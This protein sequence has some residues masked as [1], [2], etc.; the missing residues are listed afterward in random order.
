MSFALIVLI[1]LIGFL[2]FFM[3]KLKLEPANIRTNG[4]G[5]VTRVISG[6][7]GSVLLI[8][9]VWL[10]IKDYNRMYTSVEKEFKISAPT[11]KVKKLKNNENLENFRVLFQIIAVDDSSSEILF[12][13]EKVMTHEDNEFSVKD[14]FSGVNFQATVKIDGF[15]WGRINGSFSKRVSSYSSHS[16]SSG[17]IYK[18]G[19]LSED[20]IAKS[21]DSHYINYQSSFFSIKN[22]HD[23]QFRIYTLAS[24]L[25]DDDNLKDITQSELIQ[26]LDFSE[27]FNSRYY[28]TYSKSP[29]GQLTRET[30]ESLFI[31]L[32]AVGLI[33]I[34]VPKRAILFPIITAA[35]I[36]MVISLKAYEYSIHEKVAKDEEL[37]LSLRLNAAHN[38]SKSS[39]FKNSGT[40]L[41][42]K[43]K[44]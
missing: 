8:L 42:N 23:K 19:S 6:A 4:P 1:V 43:L 16:S 12:F 41:Y 3:R 40:E 29:F 15:H 24:R 39:F 28:R 34:A 33:T 17:G 7:I 11:M 9:V 26:Y 38:C 2:L 31:I 25:H 30:N 14:K 32:L 27:R 21:L 5:K 44:E 10:T 35:A 20:R 36:I 13:K 18:T 37:N 22:S